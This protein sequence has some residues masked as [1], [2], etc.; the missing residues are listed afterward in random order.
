MKVLVT[1]GLGFIGSHLVKRF[2]DE[3]REVIVVDS[4]SDF[5][6]LESLGISKGQF[7]FI[8]GDLSNF[9]IALSSIKDVDVVYHFAARI[10]G[11]HYLHGSQNVEL[12]TLQENFAIDANVFRA[13]AMNGIKKIIQASSA[14]VYPMDNQ[15]K[16][17]T[18]LKEE[19]ADFSFKTDDPSSKYK[20]PLHSDGGYGIAKAF[21][22]VELHWANDMKIG[23]ARIFNV[24]GPNRSLHEKKSHMIVDLI[25][26][27][28]YYPQE[29]FIIWGNGEQTRD[30]LF[31]SD[32]VDALL[33]LEKIVDSYSTPVVVNIGSGIGISVREIAEK[34]RN[35]SQKDMSLVFD[36]TKPVGPISRTADISRAQDLLLWSPKVSIDEGLKI[37]FEWLE[38]KINHE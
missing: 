24:Y 31:V 30:F 11:I 17:G 33:K 18:I 19:D 12:L 2:L 27:A 14:A 4:A 6:N 13:C 36:E 22:E 9:D 34:I 26:K 23:M 3:N 37:V 32:C 10:G 35:I 28:I 25:R 38:K 21:A 15:Y 5:S 16:Q 8:H 7:L 20:I 1:G 29:P